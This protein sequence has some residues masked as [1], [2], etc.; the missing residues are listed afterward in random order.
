M[1]SLEN[2]GKGLIWDGPWFR[3]IVAARVGLEL[4]LR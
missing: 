3:P 4:A 1:D 2:T